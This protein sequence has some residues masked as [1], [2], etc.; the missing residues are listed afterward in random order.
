[1]KKWRFIPNQNSTI[2]GI[3]DAGIETFT[4]NMNR[5]L[6]REIIQNS[7]DAIIPGSK[8]PVSV[9]FELFKLDR[10]QIPD[11]ENL[12]LVMKKCMDSNVDEPDAYKFFENANKVLSQSQI[13]VLRISDHNTIGLEGSDTCEKGTSWSRLV[14]ENGSSNKG[15]NSGGSFGIGKSAAFACSDLRTVFYSSLDTKQ[16]KSNFGV[17]KLVS[18]QD[19]AMGWTTGVGYY[20]EN[21]QFVAIPELAEFDPSYERKDSGTDIYVLG[22]HNS[23][24]FR[25][26]FVQAVLLDF[27]VSLVK[28][29]LIV[30]IQGEIIDKKSLPKYMAELNPYQS[31]DIKALLEYYHLLTSSDLK[32]V[33]ISLDS[34]VYGKKYGFED[35]ECV[36]YLKENEGYNRKVLITRSAGMR[37]LEQNRISGSIEFTGVLI[38]E[39]MQMNETFKAMEVPSHDA[40]EPGRCRGEEKYYTN[41]LNDFKKYIKAC[42]KD[43]FGKVS[44]DSI[45][46]IGA[47]DFLPDKIEEGK[48]PKLQKN[49]LSTR[50]KK[51][52]GKSIEPTK[53]KTKAID[54]TE[55]DLKEG[56]SGGSGPG[57][58]PGPD[59]GP[60]PHPGPGPGPEPGPEP[61]PHPGPN[62]GPDGKKTGEK[63]KYKEIPV[64]KR[65]VCTDLNEGKYV[66]SFLSPSKA[67][68]AKL[69]FSLSGEQSDFDLPIHDAKIISGASGTTVER[70]MGNKIYLNNLVKGDSLKIEIKVDFDSYCMMEVDYYANKK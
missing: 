68:K 13:D 25:D 40:W 67:T 1:M 35:G 53:K 8:D 47:S 62:P 65:L 14:K 9:E 43:S 6:V 61:G 31:E 52:L 60:G 30:N 51:L 39:G 11:I 45:D 28:G 24:E 5:S 44:S 16:L 70:T 66:L 55:A 26:A 59:P 2:V 4:A 36:L 49:D 20:S 48:Q 50:I 17:A 46:A 32:I 64:K 54:L 10:A 15:Q 58:G 29:K 33:K 38:I 42:V 3:N 34:K 56:N 57:E 7:L 63:I 22:M 37:I 69:E 12:H 23:A 27:L 21:E 18:Y 41:V 19:E